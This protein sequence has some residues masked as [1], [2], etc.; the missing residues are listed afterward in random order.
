MLRRLFTLLSALSLLLCVT[1]AAMWVRSERIADQVLCERLTASSGYFRRYSLESV[2]GRV[3]VEVLDFQGRTLP[4]GWSHMSAPTG[5][6][7]WHLIPRRMPGDRFV[8]LGFEWSFADAMAPSAYAPRRVFM[9]GVPYYFVGLPACLPPIGWLRRKVRNRSV[10]FN[11]CRH[12]G[13][14]LRATPERCPECGS[15]PTGANA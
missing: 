10:T 4:S 13:Y 14:D 9:L 15:V 6:P 5:T 11:V 8:A 12:C 1:S 2:G 3:W 7:T